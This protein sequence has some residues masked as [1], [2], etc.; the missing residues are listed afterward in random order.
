MSF[1]TKIEN[2]PKTRVVLISTILLFFFLII[3]LSIF[4]PIC[5]TDLQE[6]GTRKINKT[7]LIK[8]SIWASITFAVMFFIL[9]DGF[10]K[11]TTIEQIQKTTEQPP[12]ENQIN[13]QAGLTY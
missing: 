6:N 5:I 2:M 7:R 10:I 1:R 3:I 8:L 4:K 11:R 13:P 12:I 9:Y